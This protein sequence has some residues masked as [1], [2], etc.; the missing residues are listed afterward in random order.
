MNYL[1]M[2]ALITGYHT[3]LKLKLFDPFFDGAALINP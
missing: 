2:K 1:D 3:R